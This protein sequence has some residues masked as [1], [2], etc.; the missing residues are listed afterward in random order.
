MKEF[1]EIIQSLN[2]KMDLPQPTKARIL[3]E[4]YS[5]LINTYK[6][7]REEGIDKQHAIEKAKETFGLSTDNIGLLTE[8]HRP[9]V[10][11]FIDHLTSATIIPLERPFI[12]LLFSLIAIFISQIIIGGKFMQNASIFVYPLLLTFLITFVLSGLKFYQLFIRQDHDPARLRKGLDLITVL[13][14]LIFFLGIAGYSTETYWAAK[15]SLYLGPFF[16]ITFFGDLST[17]M[18]MSNWMMKSS[19]LM[20][21]SLSALLFSGLF[22]FILLNKIQKIEIEEASILLAE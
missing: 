5:D 7:L 8:I 11:K 4:I 9:G 12:I 1:K 15:N 19:S 3:I 10:R 18:A 13:M 16:F 20:I 22:W 17:L 21:I 2:K 6:L 14:G